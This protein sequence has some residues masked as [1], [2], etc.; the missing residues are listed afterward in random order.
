MKLKRKENGK[1]ELNEAKFSG[2]EKKLF[3]AVERI[4]G[5]ESFYRVFKQ[6]FIDLLDQSGGEEDT[7]KEIVKLIDKAAKDAFKNY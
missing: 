6:Y 5:D 1:F 3:D 4:E 7:V 2:L